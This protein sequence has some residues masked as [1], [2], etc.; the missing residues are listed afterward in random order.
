LEHL[1][2]SRL[3]SA[4]RAASLQHFTFQ[5]TDGREVFLHTESPWRLTDSS[6]IIG[7]RADY[8]R[9]ASAETTEEALDAGRLGC[10][11]RDV[12]N[13]SVRHRLNSRSVVVTSGAMDEFG[14]LTLIFNDGLKLEIFPDGSQ[15]PHDEIEF[16]RLF[17]YGKAHFVVNT[18][19]QT[20]H[21]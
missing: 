21:G 3:V 4:G 14:G 16:W 20:I 13:E 5:L 2:E 7:G 10:T 15:A 8:W 9:P 19:G 6:G 12:R 18:D 17:E 1:Q 11:L